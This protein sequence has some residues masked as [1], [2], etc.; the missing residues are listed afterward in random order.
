MTKISVVT[1]C[2]N[3]AATI[4]DTI[5]SFLRQD[6]PHKEMIVVDGESRDETVAIARSFAA[7]S[8]R[9]YSERDDGIY[10]AMNKGL[11]L[12]TGDAVGFLNSSDVFHDSGVLEKIAQ[13]LSGSDAIY[14]DLRMISAR[15]NGQVIREWRAGPFRPGAFRAGW[16]PPHPTFYLRRKL[17]KAVGAFNPR[18]DI[19]ADYDFMLRALEVQRGRVV[20]IPATLVDFT[21][22]GRSTRNIAAVLRANLQCLRS[23]HRHLKTPFL[24]SAFFIKPARKLGQIQWRLP[25]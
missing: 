5:T 15:G 14:G 21:A 10:D 1:I 23:R 9:I 6:Y 22:G 19:A 4:A 3:S 8:I 7:E 25:G 2:R 18:Y 16:M 12:F 24:D 11:K 17:V 13:G 20:Y